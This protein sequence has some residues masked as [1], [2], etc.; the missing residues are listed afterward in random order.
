MTSGGQGHGLHLGNPCRGIPHGTTNRLVSSS[1]DGRRGSLDLP[2]HPP[3]T[4]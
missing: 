4:T 2:N 1:L 3:H